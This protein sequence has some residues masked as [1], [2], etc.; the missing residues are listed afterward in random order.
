MAQVRVSIV[1][2][3]IINIININ[4]FRDFS[5]GGMISDDKVS[6]SLCLTSISYSTFRSSDVYLR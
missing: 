4:V 6:Q 2:L 1:I 5:L 3:I